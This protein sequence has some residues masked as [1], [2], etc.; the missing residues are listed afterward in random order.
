MAFGNSREKNWSVQ[1][2]DKYYEII[3]GRFLTI[4]L[5]PD[6]GKNYDDLRMGYK[7]ITVKSHII[8][9]KISEHYSVEIVRILHKRMD[10]K[11]RIIE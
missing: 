11:S 8:F 9:Y 2:A 7:A 1:Q 3:V 4:S 6:L 10:Y 5:N